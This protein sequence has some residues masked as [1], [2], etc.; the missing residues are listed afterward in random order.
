M[1]PHAGELA[2]A[3][4]NIGKFGNLDETTANRSQRAALIATAQKR[5]LVVWSRARKCYQ[6]TPVGY[7]IAANCDPQCAINFR[8]RLSSK[9][10]SCVELHSWPRGQ[11][12]SVQRI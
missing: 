3:L 11:L 6:L 4:L 9:P 12:Q 10:S 1:D 2:T 8:Q 7:R 5:G